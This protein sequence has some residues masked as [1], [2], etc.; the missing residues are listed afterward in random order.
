MTVKHH[1]QQYFRYKVYMYHECH[2]SSFSDECNWL[3]LVTIPPKTTDFQEAID[4]LNH[5]KLCKLHIPGFGWF[6][7]FNVTFNNISVISWRSILLVEETGV[8]RENHRSIVSQWQYFLTSV[9]NRNRTEKL[10]HV[11][12]F[13]FR[14]RPKLSNL[15]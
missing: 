3:H 8:L 1:Y 14:L 10:D 13:C 5:I 11:K 12:W 6:M 4:K 9:I 15:N 7:V 2:L